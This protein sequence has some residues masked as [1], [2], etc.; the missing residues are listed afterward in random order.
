M[1]LPATDSKSVAYTHTYI[2]TYIHM[3]S[4]QLEMH[5]TG[6]PDT[7]VCTI[8]FKTKEFHTALHQNYRVIFVQLRRLRCMLHQNLHNAQCYKSEALIIKIL[9]LLLETRISLLWDLNPR[10]PAYWAG[11]LP[12]KLKRQLMTRATPI[13]DGD[14]AS[15]HIHDF[16]KL[17]FWHMLAYLF[18]SL[19]S[20]TASWL[21]ILLLT[22]RPTP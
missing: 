12:T 11:A 1:T 10:P 14:V 5:A 8:K 7:I 3:S 6:C 16:K 18:V 4:R 15:N 17:F 19:K 20:T 22:H 9:I 13:T 2:H 21:L